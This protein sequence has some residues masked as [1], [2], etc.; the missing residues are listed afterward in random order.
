[1]HFLI[2]QYHVHSVNRNLLENIL[3]TLQV[4]VKEIWGSSQG[5]MEHMEALE[6]FLYT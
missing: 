2:L 1:M 3:L 5:N 6:L 4:P